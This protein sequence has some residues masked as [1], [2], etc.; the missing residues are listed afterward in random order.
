M[1]SHIKN[2]IGTIIYFHRLSVLIQ[3]KLKNQL[4]ITLEKYS[5]KFL[6]HINNMVS[7]LT[8]LDFY[9]RTLMGN[10]SSKII[11]FNSENSFAVFMTNRT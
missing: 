10:T 5:S 8:K 2:P 3:L 9:T 1:G 6:V 4:E 11:F 7:D